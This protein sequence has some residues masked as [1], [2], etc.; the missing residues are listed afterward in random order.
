M[1][2]QRSCIAGAET[3]FAPGN[4]R[5]LGGGVAIAYIMKWMRGRNPR[6]YY[7]EG[8]KVYCLFDE[9][10]PK[11]PQAAS[12][13]LIR[14]PFRRSPSTYVTGGTRGLKR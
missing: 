8:N 3:G 9:P 10:E 4:P 7:V 6:E 11:G 13:H 14:E 1:R 2:C 12:E 5:V